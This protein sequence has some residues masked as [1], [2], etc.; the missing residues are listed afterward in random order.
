MDDLFRDLRYGVRSIF[1]NFGLTLI[2]ISML[3][4]GI[5]ANT[6]IFSVI[7]ALLLRP[8]PFREA[9]RLVRITGHFNKLDVKD[10]GISVPELFDYRDSGL[11]E[12]I[13]GLYPI[14]ANLT[15]SDQPERVETLLVD[16]NYFSML[17][18]NAQLGRVFQAQDYHPGI[19]EAAIISDGLWRRRLGADPNVIGKKIRLDEDLFIVIGVAPR[20][21]RHPGRTLQTEVELWAPSGWI[22]PPFGEPSRREY[23][24]PGA[25]AR[26]KPD[27]TVASAQARIDGLAQAFRE[28]YPDDYPVKQGWVPQILWLQDDL[29]G[30]IRPTLLLLLT[31]VGLVLLIACANVANLLLARAS[32]R[33]R[34]IAIRC[35]LGASRARIIRQLMTESLLLAL[36]GG[37]AGIL[38]ALWGTDLLVKLS[39]ANTARLDEIGLNYSVLAF[40]F[41]ISVVVGILFG[42]VPALNSSKPNLQ[43][44]LK[45]AS[46]TATGGAR[47]E[48]VR[49]LMVVS[50]VT[51]A[52]MLMISA[53]LL[54]R[55]FRQLQNVD[56][57]FDS[58]NV[59]TAGL[60]L[61]LPNERETG[62][63]F[64][65]SRR[66]DFYQRALERL[67]SLPGVEKAGGVRPLPLGETPFLSAFTIEGRTT[68]PGESISAQALL[69]TPGYFETMKI[70]LLSG[71]AFTQQ[72]GMESPGVAVINQ[73]L[74]KRFFPDED[75][76]GKRIKFG[77]AQSRAPWLSVIGI[78]ADVKMEGIELEIRPQIYRS[79]FQSPGASLSLVIRT[80]SGPGA[81]P[82]AIR[83]EVQAVDP[84][85]PVFAI[86]TMDD[87]MSAATGRRRFAMILLGAFAVIAL[88]LAAVGIYGVV[89]YTVSQRTQE[90]GIR[91]ALG[92]QQADV[93]KMVIGQGMKYILVGVAAGL[94]AAFAL[95][96]LMESFLFG[97]SA[98]DP[99]TFTGVTLLMVSAALLACYVPARRATRVDPMVALRYE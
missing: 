13:S 10:A 84:D 99:L 96:H 19:S 69:S 40:T 39:P 95:T 20:G 9:E 94:A 5:G 2:V 92:A 64:Q 90:I 87:L 50:Q 6:A 89:S 11:F 41:L 33:Q 44:T 74:A 22:A 48:R 31:A 58:Q 97:V 83:R 17:G 63:Y 81:L 52:L 7:H 37:G 21:F 80:T 28:K 62:P 15:G 3:A 27:V 76:I 60:W 23:F 8:L 59:V 54:I 34:E 55:S 73:T 93:L 82:E 61:P 25:I 86:R 78:V 1:K 66:V 29:A 98:T 42:L 14:N 85:M 18:V 65:S 24:M 46:L 51:L 56:T 77:E 4:L 30:D 47:R 43:E 12:E 91:I 53:A 49:A 57:G 45:D 67:E 36:T 88:M 70:A 32:S 16:V 38:L 35:A 26:L 72:D 71:R 79:V 75:P 68:E